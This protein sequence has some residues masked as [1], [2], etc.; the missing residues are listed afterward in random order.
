MP[1]TAPL[2][3]AERQALKGRAHRLNPVVMIAESGLTESVLAEIDRNLA[4]H[5]LIK[6][7]VFNAD[8]DVREGLLAQ[9][10]ATTGARPVQHIGKILVVYREK[11]AEAKDESARPAAR[12]PAKRRAPAPAR[13]WF[14]RTPEGR[15]GKAPKLG[16]RSASA[17]RR[18]AKAPRTRE[19]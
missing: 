15:P 13:A 7:R 8:R 12:V 18:A 19:E 16:P 4:A 17:K 2:T 1:P 9:I 5:G 10:C 3:P 6:I 11:P 14:N